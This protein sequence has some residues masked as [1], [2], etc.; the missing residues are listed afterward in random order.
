MFWIQTV[1]NFSLPNNIKKILYFLKKKERKK[2][3]ISYNISLI[4]SIGIQGLLDHE[5][6]FL[7]VVLYYIF[8]SFLSSRKWNDQTNFEFIWFFQV[9]VVCFWNQLLTTSLMKAVSC[10]ASHVL[11]RCRDFPFCIMISVK[12]KIF[13]ISGRECCIFYLSLNYCGKLVLFLK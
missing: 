5:A 4:P 7:L 2:N 3:R 1:K 10:Y 9:Y 11:F 8:A 13:T 12:T 6:R